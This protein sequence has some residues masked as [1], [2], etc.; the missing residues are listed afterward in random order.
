[1]HHI[2]LTNCTLKEE[3][4]DVVVKDIYRVQNKYKNLEFNYLTGTEKTKLLK[5]VLIYMQNIFTPVRILLISTS[6]SKAQEVFH[7]RMSQKENKKRE[8]M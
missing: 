4:N 1:M 3:N 5:D 7:P 2:S 8:E 6:L